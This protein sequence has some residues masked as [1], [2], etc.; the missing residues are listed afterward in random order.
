VAEE[1]KSRLSKKPELQDK[2]V[3]NWVCRA[4]CVL[5]Y[6]GFSDCMFLVYGL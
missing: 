4:L 3:P 1:M 5:C 6:L 2:L